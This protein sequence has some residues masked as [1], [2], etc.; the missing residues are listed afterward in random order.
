MPA[1]PSPPHQAGQQHGH[2]QAQQPH[3]QHGS[4]TYQ[5]GPPPGIVQYGGPGPGGQGSGPGSKLWLVVALVVVLVLAVGGAL[6]LTVFNGDDDTP[7]ASSSED[8]T[9]EP[10][11]DPTA[12]EETADVPTE[13]TEE[14]TDEPTEEPTEEPDEPASGDDLPLGESAEVGDYVVSV[15]GVQQDADEVIAQTNQFND[16]PQDRYVLV[17]L[18][19]EYGGGKGGD[20]W[21]DLQPSFVDGTGTEHP[22]YECSAVVPKPGFEVPTLKKGQSGSYQV[23]FDV[24]VDAIAGGTIRVGDTYDFDAPGVTWALE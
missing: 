12:S 19:V 5:G 17:D 14:P 3:Q 4:P 6:A 7:A 13:P 21:L 8:S 11:D 24:P 18:S 16:K 2:Q 15:D 9:D 1:A 23:C 20:A 22:A 10:S